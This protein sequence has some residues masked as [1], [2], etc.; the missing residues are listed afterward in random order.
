MPVQIRREGDYIRPVPAGCQS[1]CGLHFVGSF[2]PRSS[3]AA[4]AIVPSKSTPA[5]P[6][7]FRAG[8]FL[9]SDIAAAVAFGQS[10]TVSKAAALR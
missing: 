4:T 7:K 1:P 8:S 5:A 9:Y 6:S 2:D 3:S 10:R